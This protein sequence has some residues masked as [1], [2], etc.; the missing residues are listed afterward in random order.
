M[1]A[2]IYTTKTCPFCE[3]VK[4]LLTYKGVKYIEKNAELPE[5]REEAIKVSGAMTVPITIVNGKTLVGFNQRALM[6][7]LTA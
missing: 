1:N 4:K 6:E 7:A 3:V 5:I 2:I